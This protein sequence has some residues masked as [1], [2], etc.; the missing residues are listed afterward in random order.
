MGVNGL[1]KLLEPVGRPITLESLEN[2]TLAVDVSLWL[3]QALY[4]MKNQHGSTVPNAHLVLLFQRICKL[5]HYRIKPIFV[6]D[7]GVP[8]LKKKTM[9]ARRS[10]RLSARNKAQ[11]ISE[12]VLKKHLKS[13]A[14]GS[15]TGRRSQRSSDVLNQ[16]ER[17]KDLFEL[18]PLP[19]R[20][21]PESPSVDES[22]FQS[23]HFQDTTDVNI[24]S[25]EF[26][27]LPREIQHEII[28]EM[29]EKSKRHSRY[30]DIDMPEECDD[31]SN[32]QLNHLLKRGKLTQRLGTI[33]KEMNEKRVGELVV[34]VADS[35]MNVNSIIQ[36]QKIMSEETGHYILIKRT[37][38]R[39]SDDHEEQKEDE[40]AGGFF[41]EDGNVDEVELKP[42]FL[43]DLP[44]VSSNV[45]KPSMS[46]SLDAATSSTGES[47]DDQEF[48]D[49]A[50]KVLPTESA[51]DLMKQSNNFG[52]PEREATDLSNIVMRQATGKENKNDA[53]RK[54]GISF[55]VES[56]ELKMDINDDKVHSNENSG[57]LTGEISGNIPID[58]EYFV[59]EGGDG[60]LSSSQY[61]NDTLDDSNTCV[62][63][64]SS[65]IPKL[66]ETGEICQQELS[67]EKTI[68][69]ELDDLEN[70]INQKKLLIE[71]LLSNRRT[72]NMSPSDAKENVGNLLEEK[73]LCDE[74]Q[75]NLSMQ[76]CAASD[77]SL[78]HGISL[79]N[80][81]E[82][83]NAGSNPSTTTS[84]D[85]AIPLSDTGTS[86]PTE[87]DAPVPNEFEGI[88]YE[89]LGE[90]Q[91]KLD[92]DLD[93]L[94]EERSRQTRLA[95]TVTDE[96]YKDSQELLQLFGIPFVVSPMEAE[97]Q[98]AT[99]NRNNL[100]DG[101]ITED[102]DIILFG[103]KKVYKN[104]FN[105]KRDAEI[106]QED[107]VKCVLGLDRLNLIAIALLTGSDYTEGI[108]GIGIVSAMEII[109]EFSGEG[110]EK[111][112]NLK[113]WLYD[114]SRHQLH[115]S[116]VKNKLKNI[117]LPI[118]FPSEQ[119]FEAYL[120]PAVDDSK[121]AFSW[122]N[123]DLHSLRLYPFNFSS[124]KRVI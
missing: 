76:V 115:E 8:E 21:E 86:R 22:F 100:C 57:T 85:I 77:I 49:I 48:E 123:P 53:V 43:K 114:K 56:N 33:R 24:D 10:I 68:N 14:I 82:S 94:K 45:A 13:R 60:T 65:S 47:S 113:S 92:E 108:Q 121:E 40:M 101:S 5:L 69:T 58:N 46:M 12:N 106:Y 95:A 83:K 104:I 91:M 97:A 78:Q 120:N 62:S 122:A 2:K 28:V 51:S 18:P 107:D 34:D 63:T 32:F 98:C 15:V 110:I 119:V 54:E 105:Q 9:A 81:N 90:M 80:D 117:S 99:L 50:A 96:M 3:N 74:G 29:H 17:E 112:Q 36:S 52:I 7:G 118:G 109:N 64:A 72:S 35:E 1:W 6:F 37:A 39:K 55:P 41:R 59:E 66:S 38:A 4:G 75:N 67:P 44:K 111:L 124:K 19:E 73:S 26:K 23:H 25:E 89:E 42:F 88:T 70:E 71:K 20:K 93:S 16:P 102:S 31:F 116:K 11:K 87:I 30:Q 27:K 79:S 84:D 61:S 103:S